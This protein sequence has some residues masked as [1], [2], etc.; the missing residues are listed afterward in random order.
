MTHALAAQVEDFTVRERAWRP[1]GH[2]VERHEAPDLAVRD[3]RIGR[4]GEPLVHRAALVRLDVPERDPP[5]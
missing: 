2:V 3:L 1:V 4:G 5:Q